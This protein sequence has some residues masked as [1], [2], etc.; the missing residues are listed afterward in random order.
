[1]L[2]VDPNGGGGGGSPKIRLVLMT[3]KRSARI[4]LGL[5]VVVES[6]QSMPILTRRMMTLDP[7]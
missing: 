5:M 7:K 6:I 2:V 4:L 1:M 3:R